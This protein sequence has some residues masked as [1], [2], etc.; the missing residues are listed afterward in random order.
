MEDHEREMV[1]LLV[2]LARAESPTPDPTAQGD[3]QDILR[4]AFGRAGYAVRHLGAAAGGPDGGRLLVRPPRSRRTNAYQ[5]MVGHSDTVWDRGTLDTMPIEIRDGRLHG[6]GTFDMKAG[7]VQMVFAVRALVELDLTPEVTPVAWITTDEEIGSPYSERQTELL[8]RRADRALIIE[9]S[10]GPTGLIKTGRKGN[11]NYQVTVRGK[12]AHAGLDP[13]AGASAILAAAGLIR[14]L[15]ELNDYEGGTTVS[16]G[17]I[18]GGTRPNVVPA[19]CRFAIDFRASTVADIEAVTS[20]IE[21]LTPDIPGTTVE[22]EGG[23][24]RG[25]L[26]R[27]PRNQA[28]WHAT[29]AAGAALGM[30]L[31]EVFVGGG[32]DGN[33]TS[34]FTPTIDGLG[35]VGDGA[36]ARHEHVVVRSLPERSGLLAMIL[37][38]PALGNGA[39]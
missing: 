7:L 33:I 9:P 14:R 26:E 39:G 15:H 35:P 1:D 17:L 12:A 37:L 8:A 10:K 27:T 13:E 23:A 20:A 29:R 28:L 22:F 2:E 38:E 24:E 16:V 30:Q 19:E 5:M 18:E 11:G 36:H 21:A 3:S 6:P 25:P 32:S 31:D 4:E 34:A